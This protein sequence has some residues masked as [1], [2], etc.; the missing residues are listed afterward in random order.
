MGGERVWGGAYAIHSTRRIFLR[1]TAHLE[2][3]LY[4]GARDLAD[5]DYAAESGVQEGFE[6]ALSWT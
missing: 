4:E 1:Q 5:E 6:V 2:R 3:E